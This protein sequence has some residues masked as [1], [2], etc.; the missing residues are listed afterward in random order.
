MKH[1]LL[2]LLFIASFS[3]YSADQ[4][5]YGEKSTDYS[6][7]LKQQRAYHV[8]LSNNYYQSNRQSPIVFF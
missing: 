5:I 4:L 8:K 7:I 6:K 1:C 2:A 3:S